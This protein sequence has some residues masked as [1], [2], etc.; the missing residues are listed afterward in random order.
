MRS[1]L[2]WRK[3][4]KFN[5]KTRKKT[6]DLID[7]KSPKLDKETRRKTDY[8]VALQRVKTPQNLIKKTVEENRMLIDGLRVGTRLWIKGLSTTSTSGATKGTALTFLML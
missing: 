3:P 1:W 8:F 2:W 6:G 5:E 7:E 4:P